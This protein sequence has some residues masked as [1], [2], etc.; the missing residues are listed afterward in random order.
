M[1]GVAAVLV[2]VDAHRRRRESGV[3]IDEYVENIYEQI[4]QRKEKYS[5]ECD[6][7]DIT[8]FLQECDDE[9]YSDEYDDWIWATYTR[10]SFSRDDKYSYGHIWKPLNEI[11]VS[12]LQE[13]SWR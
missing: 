13:V 10:W 7:G 12:D 2:A 6:C 3:E 8:V 5:C 11:E 4:Q 9:Q 1:E